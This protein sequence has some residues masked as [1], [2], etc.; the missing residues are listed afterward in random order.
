MRDEDFRQSTNIEDLRGSSGGFGGSNN[1]AFGGGGL[2]VRTGGGFGTIIIIILILIFG[3]GRGLLESVTSGG[4]DLSEAGYQAQETNGINQGASNN[5]TE[6]R[7]AR[8][9]ANVLGSTE[10]YWS[11]Y[12]KQSGDDYPEPVLTMFRGSTSSP[13]GTASSQTG[14]FYCPSN[15]KVY[16][17]IDFFDEMARSLGADGDFAQAYVIAH[18]IGHHVQNITGI[19]PKAHKAM[20]RGGE[21]KGA[22]S[23][24]V[25]IEL[26]ADCLAGTWAKVAVQDIGKLETGDIEEA[27]NAAQ[28]VGDDR[29]QKRAQGY[30]VPD[31]FTHGTSQQRMKWFNLGMKTGNPDSCDTFN[32]QNL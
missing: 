18:E 1:G 16:L 15:Q 13:C 9:I 31:S 14:P 5:Q 21:R 19:L 11:A 24:A 27:M 6:E 29:L 17:D 7:T 23:I 22:D 28:A 25:R 10:D 26:Q 2:P 3:G 32:T 12:F 30:A 20:A 8:R 4:G